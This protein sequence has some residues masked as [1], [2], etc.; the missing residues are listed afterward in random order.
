VDQWVASDH[1]E[2]IVEIS[3]DLKALS[4]EEVEQIKTAIAEKKKPKP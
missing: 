2:S 3:E 1:R 4:K